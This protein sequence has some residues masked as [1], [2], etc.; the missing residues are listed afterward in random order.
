MT[1]ATLDGGA[2]TVVTDR[3]QVRDRVRT[4]AAAQQVDLADDADQRPVLVHDRGPQP[5]R[6]RAAAGRLP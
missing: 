2:P 4:E 3:E 5:R 6:D 1:S